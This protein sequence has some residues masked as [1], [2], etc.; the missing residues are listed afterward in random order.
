[1]SKPFISKPDD[2][3]V[4]SLGFLLKERFLDDCST[5]LKGHR[6]T[7]DQLAGKPKGSFKKHIKQMDAAQAAIEAERKARI[8]KA[9]K[10]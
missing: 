4:P 1:M 9:R 2:N 6:K 8:R 5:W 7:I 10:T 3:A